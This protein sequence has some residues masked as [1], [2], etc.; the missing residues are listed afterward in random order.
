MSEP[1]GAQQERALARAESVSAAVAVDQ[2]MV[3]GEVPLDCGKGRANAVVLGIK[4]P[5][6]GDE[7]GGRV[8]VVAV[9]RLAE[10]PNSSLQPRVSMASRTRS[11]AAVHIRKRPSPPRMSPP[12]RSLNASPPSAAHSGSNIELKDFGGWDPEGLWKDVKFD[13]SHQD[14]MDRIAIVG[15]NKWEEWGTKLSKPFFKVDMRFFT[16]DRAAEARAWFLRD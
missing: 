4:E 2:S 8:E 16:P 6:D 3:V 13:A 15:E 7:Q 5:H 1:E 11:R 9:E 14:D 10:L 12:F